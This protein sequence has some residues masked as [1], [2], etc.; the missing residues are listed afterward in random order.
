M[1]PPGKAGPMKTAPSTRSGC[2]A[3]SSKPRWPPSEKPTITARSVPVASSTASASSANS[4]SSYA[5]GSGGR[6]DL[7]LPR[8]SNAT[9]R[10]WR[11]R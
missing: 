10:Q 7:P 11:A 2:S 4:R 9:T 3:A 6:S 8:P 5:A 1:P